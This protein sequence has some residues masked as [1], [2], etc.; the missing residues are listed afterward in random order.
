[1]HYIIVSRLRALGA[2][3]RRIVLDEFS[4]TR[5]PIASRRALTA[6]DR[7]YHPSCQVPLMH[8]YESPET[9]TL[10]PLAISP[11]TPPTAL[12]PARARTASPSPACPVDTRAAATRASS[13]ALLALMR[14]EVGTRLAAAPLEALAQGLGGS[15]ARAPRRRVLPAGLTEREVEV[16]ALVARGASNRE[17][18]HQLV[19]TEKTAGHHLEHIYDKI[20]V[21]SRAAA[22]FYAMQ[23]RLLP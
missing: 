21:S 18:A 8:S 1:M 7:E 23:H 13:P 11:P 6:L 17:I 19:I 22:V 20:G 9:Q 15:A 2:G 3:L 14:Q 12:R 5:L 16:L 4:S 10:S